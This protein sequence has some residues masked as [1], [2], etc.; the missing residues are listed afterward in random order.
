MYNFVICNTED[1]PISFERDDNTFYY[2]Y[3]KL[4]LFKGRILYTDPFAIVSSIPTDEDV[5]PDNY[6]IYI[7]ME[8]GSIWQNNDYTVEQIA[9][10]SDQS[11][12]EYLKASGATYFAKSDYRYLDLQTKSIILPYH[13]GK[14]Q[15]GLS[16]ANDLAIDENLI[17]K[18]DPKNSRFIFDGNLQEPESGDWHRIQDYKGYRSDTVETVIE[19][20]VVKSN[21]RVST[22][23]DNLIKTYGDGLFVYT[24]DRAKLSDFKKLKEYFE[25]YKT[26]IDAYQSIV[27]EAVKST[28]ETLNTLPEKIL[29]AMEVYGDNIQ[30]ALEKYDEIVEEY[31]QLKVDIDSYMTES[32][33]ELY[34]Q[35]ESFLQSINDP[36]R[37]F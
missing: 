37:Y 26:D 34:E 7:Y 3:D 2:V 23:A 18:F 17:V 12:L 27:A 29:D 22:A 14:Y 11:Q 21:V 5:L 31:E 25:A 32:T 30:E 20:G 6:M 8:D 36:W 13:N 33:G 35:V 28:A 4:V 16:L 9:T 15:L 19:D 24:G 10:L 1:L